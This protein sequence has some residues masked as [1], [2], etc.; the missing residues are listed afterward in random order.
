VCIPVSCAYV[1]VCL[2]SKPE[3]SNTLRWSARRVGKYFS[4]SREPR[5]SGSC[6]AASR[7]C[8]RPPSGRLFVGLTPCCA[9]AHSTARSVGTYHGEPDSCCVAAFSYTIAR[10]C[11][12]GC[13]V[14]CWSA[15]APSS[16]SSI[17]AQQCWHVRLEPAAA[18]PPKAE[19][20]APLWGCRRAVVERTVR[21][22]ILELACLLRSTRSGQD[23]LWP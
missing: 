17:G 23:A 5:A 9:E 8:L 2:R 10:G 16:S 22:T 7:A 6:V 11:R 3:A 1:P 18:E 19:Q 12:C 20:A 14:L 21:T 4:S 15:H 13:R